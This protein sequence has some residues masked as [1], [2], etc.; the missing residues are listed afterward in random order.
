ML[1]A[2][3]GSIHAQEDED[4]NSFMGQRCW[5]I[6]ILFNKEDISS[7]HLIAKNHRDF[8]LSL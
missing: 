6:Y 7:F 3:A 4:K 5:L 2:D 8:L 1:I